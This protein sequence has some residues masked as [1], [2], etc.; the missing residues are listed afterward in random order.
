MRVIL[1]CRAVDLGLPAWNARLYIFGLF[2]SFPFYFCYF[3]MYSKY[4]FIWLTHSVFSGGNRDPVTGARNRKSKVT[5]FSTR[6]PVQMATAQQHKPLK[7][8]DGPLVW[9]DCEMT[10]LN[11]RA[12]KILE[13]AV[14]PRSH[15][16]RYNAS[17]VAYVG[18]YHRRKAQT[19]G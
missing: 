3:F 14:S 18:H 1:S 12:D 11:P 9:I 7:L 17:H 4:A 5:I 19:C 6:S 2:D 13:I 8:R 10:G 16:E 15:R